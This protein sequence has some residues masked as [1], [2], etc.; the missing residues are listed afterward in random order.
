MAKLVW[1]VKLITELEPGIVS[2]T[3]VAR[4]ERDDL[5]APE[6]LGLT[7]E[8]GK[9]LTA[10][11]QAEIVRAQVSTMGERFRWCEH[12]G[13]KLLSKGYYPAMFRSVF[14]DV[15]VR[16][17]RLRACGCRAGKA[18]PRS[19]AAMFA[20][21]GVAP[22]LAY[23]TAKFA[24]LVPF[25]RVGD[26]FAELLPVSGAPNAGTVR[27][28]TMRVGAT[29][30]T[31]T[32]ADAPP[33]E[34][35]AV[36]SAVIVGLDG[37]YVRSRHRRPERNFEVIAGKVIDARGA[38][39]RFA[40]ARN[41]GAAD[42][43]A[44]ALVRAGVRGGTASTVLSDGDAGLWNL[45]RTVLPG[46]TV[47]LD[48]F[49]I[50]M[51]FEHVLR[52]TAGVGAGTIDAHLGAVARRDIE[53]AKWCLWHGR[54]KRC[55][56]KLVTTFRRS[57]AKCIR[58]V[59]GIEALRRHLRDLIDY[60]EDNTAMLVNYGARRHYG[61]PISTAFV[62]SAVNEI[63]SRRMIKK[64]QMR[65]NRWTVKPFLDVRVAVLN[66]TLEGA[67]RRSYPDFRPVNQNI[68]TAAAA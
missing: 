23:I 38:Q 30:A 37:G 20:T 35:D 58:D 33:L 50:A 39:H 61:E 59:A 31:L 55:L 9:Q 22:E 65:W 52:A 8:E 64:Q 49:H 29:I 68:E 24:A 51:R 57:E 7:L 3:E 45:Q 17:R 44:R 21:G 41:G 12:C 56:V 26:L 47:V 46:A 53:R 25:A 1:R 67:F 63:V 34:P 28:R 32:A 48:W 40:F 5:A 16:I 36:T 2:E 15:D 14:G 11:T 43:F 60:L 10:A 4:V 18:E 66:G 62:E 19:F 42:D 6:T 27:N 13:A 54:W